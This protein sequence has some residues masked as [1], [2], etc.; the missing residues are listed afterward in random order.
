MGASGVALRAIF[1]PYW[2]WSGLFSTPGVS[3]FVTLPTG[4]RWNSRRRC[5]TT[6]KPYS[7]RFCR[8]TMS[9]ALPDVKQSDAIYTGR[10][11]AITV[12]HV[13][14]PDGRVVKME[15]VRHRGSVVLLP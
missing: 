3:S 1:V 15:C 13:A 5:L 10:V 9:E 14:F 2:R 11:F 6:C 4:A 12:D 7:I 8:T